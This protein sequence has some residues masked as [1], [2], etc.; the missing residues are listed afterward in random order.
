M[1]IVVDFWLKVWYIIQYM[2]TKNIKTNNMTIVRNVAYSQI[3]KMS[4]NIKEVIEVDTTLLK[5]IDI[6]M[7]NAINKI[8]YDYNVYQQTGVLKIK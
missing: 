7:K 4:K 6:N 5:M 8:I 1:P 3:N 2:I